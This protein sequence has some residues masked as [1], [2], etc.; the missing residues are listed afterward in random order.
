MRTTSTLT[1]D[2]TLVAPNHMAAIELILYGSPDSPPRLP[3]PNEILAI[4]NE[5][6]LAEDVTDPGTYFILNDKLVEDLPDDPGTY[7]I[8]EGLYEDPD[9]PGTYLS[10]EAA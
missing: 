8:N 10:G 3:T 1:I 5:F 6:A 2:S 4:V 7:I 9:D